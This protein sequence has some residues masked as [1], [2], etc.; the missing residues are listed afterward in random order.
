LCTLND[1]GIFNCEI[2]KEITER[3]NRKLSS[4]LM[5]DITKRKLVIPYQFLGASYQFHLPR[6]RNSGRKSISRC[7]RSPYLGL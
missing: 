3:R 7:R 1:K 5:W 6:A 2:W 4:A